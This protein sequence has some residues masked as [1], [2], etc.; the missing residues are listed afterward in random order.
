MLVVIVYIYVF[1]KNCLYCCWVVS[2]PD[3]YFGNQYS[4]DENSMQP[5]PYWWKLNATSETE[6]K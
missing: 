1:D 5:V 3:N 4:T 6:Q 2:A